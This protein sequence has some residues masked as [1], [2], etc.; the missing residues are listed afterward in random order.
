M[1]DPDS[2]AVSEA[3]PKRKRSGFGVLAGA[4]NI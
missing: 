2:S 3:L 1:P 4:V